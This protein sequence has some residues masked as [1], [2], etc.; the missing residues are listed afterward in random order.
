L[1]FQ[2]DTTLHW[3][4][5][6]VATTELK[7]G[8]FQ[9]RRLQPS[10]SYP[11]SVTPTPR[12]N[13][14]PEYVAVFVNDNDERVSLDLFKV[15]SMT[16][17]VVVGN[18]TVYERDSFAFYPVYPDYAPAGYRVLD[19]DDAK[20]NVWRCFDTGNEKLCHSV[21]RA[22]YGIAWSLFTGDRKSRGDSFL[23]TQ[24][25]LQVRYNGGMGGWTVSVRFLCA[26]PGSADSLELDSLGE[27]SSGNH[28]IL[29]SWTTM[30]CPGYPISFRE[31]SGG[32]VFL[33]ILLVLFVYLLGLHVFLRFLWN[34]SIEIPHEDFWSGFADSLKAAWAAI[35]SCRQ[36]TANDLRPEPLL[37]PEQI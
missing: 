1:L 12:P 31:Q 33:I 5:Y 11:I 35:W 17:S 7:S 15:N 29:Y 36:T 16:R 30:V 9:A 6:L 32:S 14:L 25:G 10:F 19:G 13:A 3:D 8:A 23:G 2:P 37:T 24:S 4:N 28:I 22:A 21:G 27:I 18:G 26:E 34:G 20:A